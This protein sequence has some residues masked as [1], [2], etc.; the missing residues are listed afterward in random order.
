MSTNSTFDAM[1]ARD[2]NRLKNR[3]W[4]HNGRC[5]GETQIARDRRAKLAAICANIFDEIGGASFEQLDDWIAKKLKAQ[6]PTPFKRRKAQ[7]EMAKFFVE[8]HA[9][10]VTYQDFLKSRIVDDEEIVKNANSEFC[11]RSYFVSKFSTYSM[12]CDDYVFSVTMADFAHLGIDANIQ[13]LLAFC[14]NYLDSHKWVYDKSNNH[15]WVK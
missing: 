3:A 8:N 11:I 15:L 6:F 13:E 9:K 2:L 14:V 12:S 5:A 1:N 10:L 7:L 4:K